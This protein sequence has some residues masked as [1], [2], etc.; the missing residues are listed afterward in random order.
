MSVIVF[1]KPMSFCRMKRTD[2]LRALV[3]KYSPDYMS[4]ARI[5]GKSFHRTFTFKIEIEHITA[6]SKEIR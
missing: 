5:Y 3:G 6:K 1:G 4:W 2:G